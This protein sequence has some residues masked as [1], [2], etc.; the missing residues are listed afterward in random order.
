[1]KTIQ[2]HFTH[3]LFIV[4]V[5]AMSSCHSSRNVATLAAG[6]QWH[7]VY[8]PVKVK[9]TSP[10]SMSL[11]GRATIV[12]DSLVNVSMRVLG[13]EVAVVNMTPDSVV[14]VDKYHKY[15]FAES[16]HSLMGSHNLS[17]GDIQDI[18]LGLKPNAP[19]NQLSFNNPG[20]EKPVT[21]SFSD[22]VETPAGNISQ[23]VAVEA[24]LSKSEVAAEL[25][26]SASSAEWNSGRTVDFVTPSKGY[27]RVTVQ[28]ALNSFKNM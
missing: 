14:F 26:W 3:I 6:T 19:L 28:N 5:L 8:M 13:M 15:L 1:M 22:F 10:M 18:I 17:L 16:L 2:Q 20:S 11:S 25:I 21:V 12:R 27:K 7:D 4:L 23:T 24:P 9:L